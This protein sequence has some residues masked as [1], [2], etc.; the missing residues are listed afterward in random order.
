MTTS[1]IAQPLYQRSPA[2]PRQG[3]DRPEDPRAEGEWRGEDGMPGTRL[4]PA[5]RADLSQGDVFEVVR[6]SGPTALWV[7]NMLA[8]VHVA[9]LVTGR[10]IE[11]RPTG[12]WG[13]W[14]AGGKDRNPD[15]RISLSSQARFYSKTRFVDTYIHELSHCLLERESKG[16][17][18]EECPGLHQHD[19][20][21]YSLNLCL[22]LRLERAKLPHYLE[23]SDEMSLY[24][25]QDPI[26][27]W[28]DK[29]KQEWQPRSIAWSMAQA[30]DLFNTDLPAEKL[31][32]EI[33]ERYWVWA[34][35]M[36]AEPLKL[37]KEN[38]I[39][40]QRIAHER[41]DRRI[42]KNNL[43]FFQWLTCV[44]VVSFFAIVYFS[45]GDR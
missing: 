36:A 28:A 34:D 8:P 26:P 3:D 7:T 17:D 31:A 35:L 37:A 18:G 42:L 14:S 16:P 15:G 32:A 2:L 9:L 25:L 29:P 45:F 6:A 38:L 1:L 30:N 44:L 4:A 27:A 5:G 20:C 12:R 33:A 24:D 40:S 19:A 39:A 22:L 43:H 11:F 41:E 21:F 10:P 13:G 23:W